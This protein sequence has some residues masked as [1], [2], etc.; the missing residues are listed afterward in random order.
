[1]QLIINPRNGRAILDGQA[2]VIDRY[3]DVDDEYRVIFRGSTQWPVIQ[4][5]KGKETVETVSIARVSAVAGR[6]ANG[7]PLMQYY[8]VDIAPPQPIFPQGAVI[9]QLLNSGIERHRIHVMNRGQTLGEYVS[10]YPAP[11]MAC[12]DRDA[13]IRTE[14]PART[15]GGEDLEDGVRF[16]VDES[17]KWAILHYQW[18]GV[19]SIYLWPEA[20]D[21][22]DALFAKIEE[23]RV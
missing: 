20:A 15:V 14:V 12:G 5:V 13:L 3:Y 16:T 21:D 6:G 8:A 23:L 4:L 17:A 10:A 7:A 2:V 11:L 9:K 22:A 1:V 18:T 19:A